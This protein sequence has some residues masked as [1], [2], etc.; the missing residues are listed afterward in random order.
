MLIKRTTE[1][2]VSMTN[3]QGDHTW[4]RAILAQ[5]NQYNRFCPDT[6]HVRKQGGIC[7]FRGGGGL[8]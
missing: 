8:T 2:E 3:E 1:F 4:G 5:W 6:C 7:Q